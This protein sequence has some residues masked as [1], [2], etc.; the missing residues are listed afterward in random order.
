MPGPNCVLCHKRIRNGPAPPLTGEYAGHCEKC[1]RKARRAASSSDS[2][3]NSSSASDCES[4]G[5][6]ELGRE[7][8]GS[9]SG[10]ES[11][12]SESGSKSDGS[13]AARR[14]PPDFSVSPLEQQRLE[15]VGGVGGRHNRS[16]ER[17]VASA[18]LTFSDWASAKGPRVAAAGGGGGG[19]GGSGATAG[20][21]P[22][23]GDG[24]TAAAAAASTPAPRAKRFVRHRR[25]LHGEGDGVNADAQSAKERP[26]DH[27]ANAVGTGKRL[28]HMEL[29]LPWMERHLCCRKC[30]ETAAKQNLTTNA[31]FL[32]EKFSKSG[33]DFMP[34]V[35]YAA[36]TRRLQPM[37]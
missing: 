29:L 20:A 31:E 14:R 9:E 5:S 36:P 21:V 15:K 25:H 8:A 23:D 17:E 6:T 27:M 11:T 32:E 22:S 2:G 10:S 28:I 30:S 16:R 18:G 26:F 4:S 33:I 37:H 19:G 35:A 24:Q 34:E 12:W 1:R 13:P 3:S 7:S